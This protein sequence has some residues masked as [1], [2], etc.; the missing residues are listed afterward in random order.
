MLLA[1]FNHP[2]RGEIDC[3][4]FHTLIVLGYALSARSRKINMTSAIL[5]GTPYSES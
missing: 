4:A 3:F 1:E 5:E 2:R